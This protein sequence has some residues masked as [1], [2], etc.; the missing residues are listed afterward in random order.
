MIARIAISGDVDVDSPKIA[1]VGAENERPAKLFE[2]FFVFFAVFVCD[3]A[4]TPA[5]IRSLEHPA[6]VLIEGDEQVS[7]CVVL[8]GELTFSTVFLGDCRRPADCFVVFEAPNKSPDAFGDWLVHTDDCAA[9]I[10]WVE[11]AML[12]SL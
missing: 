9:A 7:I 1:D 4:F 8:D 2:S 11:F 3:E 10:C 5:A 12:L 6:I